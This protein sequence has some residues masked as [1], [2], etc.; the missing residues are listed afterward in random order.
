MDR[1]WYDAFANMFGN[2]PSDNSVRA[3]ARAGLPLYPVHGGIN[4]ENGASLMRK[5]SEA[6]V[7]ARE[8]L[9]AADTSKTLHEKTRALNPT[10][11]MTKR[12]GPKVVA[13]EKAAS[14]LVNTADGENSDERLV[15][16]LTRAFTKA[17]ADARAGGPMRGGRK[18]R[19]GTKSARRK[20]GTAV[21]SK[22]RSKPRSTKRRRKKLSGK[23]A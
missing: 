7:R 14:A 3:R 19:T 11:V 1:G 13:M 10:M 20:G 15:P 12:A 9:A 2:A 6:L 18:R 21:K 5:Q 4:D 8:V 22:A 17:A 23:R 16:D